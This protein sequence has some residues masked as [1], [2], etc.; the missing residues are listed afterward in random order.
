MVEALL[1]SA[2]L[3]VT[4]SAVLLPFSTAGRLEQ[5]DTRLTT[6]SFLAEGLMNEIVAKPFYDPD[7]AST[8]GPETGEDDRWDYDNLD[9]YHGYS[10]SA[11]ALHDSQEVPISGNA[12]RDLSREV[13]VEYVRPK[14]QPDSE[15]LN[16]VRI[17][18]KAC[19]RGAEMVV[20]TRL[21][22]ASEED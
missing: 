19:H 8:P 22:R 16:F 10:E 3:A 17:T 1:A 20:L 9:D 13:A 4:V 7:G 5:F 6:C 18:V 2:L 14:Y 11:G 15:D 21:V 12:F